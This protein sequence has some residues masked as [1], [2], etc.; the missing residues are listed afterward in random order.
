MPLGHGWLVEEINLRPAREHA[1][2]PLMVE[3]GFSTVPTGLQLRRH[4]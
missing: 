4:R 1:L 3:A 2:A